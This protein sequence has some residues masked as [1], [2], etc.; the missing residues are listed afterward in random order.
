MLHKGS[1]RN[2]NIQKPTWNQDRNRS[3]DKLNSEYGS[4][5]SSG[6]RER[7]H[8]YQVRLHKRKG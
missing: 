1:L 2:T 3:G 6:Y 5:L 4:K 7:S 8:D